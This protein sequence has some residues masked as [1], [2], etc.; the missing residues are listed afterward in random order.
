MRI[1][2]GTEGLAVVSNTVV[3]QAM[4]QSGLSGCNRSPK[5]RSTLG[6]LLLWAIGV[7]AQVVD[8][9]AALVKFTRPQLDAAIAHTKNENTRLDGLHELIRM[10]GPRLYEASMIGGDPDPEIFKMEGEA[11]RTVWACRDV[12]T[13]G[14]ALDSPIRNVRLWAVLSFETR[15]EYKDAWQPL[16]PKLVKMLSDPDSGFRQSAVDKLW[17]YPEGRHAIAEYAPFETDPDGLLRI[18][19]SGGSPD[20]YRSLVRLLSSA[21]ANVRE[22]TLSFIYLNLWNKATASIWKVGFNQDVYERVRML[23]T[24]PSPTEKERALKALSQLDPLKRETE[25]EGQK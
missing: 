5:M 17:F 23:S 24:S 6:L 4:S 11:A 22:S 9:D 19:R 2:F 16:V 1:V 8:Q 15:S 12:A 3:T 13:V 14:K 20:F 10:A 25:S 7:T 18:A 21:D